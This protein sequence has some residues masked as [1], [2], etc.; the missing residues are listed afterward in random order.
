[1]EMLKA[2]AM[3]DG[4]VVVCGFYNILYI[5]PNIFMKNIFTQSY[6]SFCHKLRELIERVKPMK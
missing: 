1:M 6:Y 5:Y 4:M 3:E 2:Q